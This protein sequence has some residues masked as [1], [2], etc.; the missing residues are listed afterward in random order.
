M[1]YDSSTIYWV[2]IHVTVLALQVKQQSSI[3]MLLSNTAGILLSASI[4]QPCM[5]SVRFFLFGIVFPNFSLRTEGMS[6]SA[7]QTL[8]S[9]SGGKS[10]WA[11]KSRCR[12]H[13]PEDSELVILNLGRCMHKLS[14][15]LV[16]RNLGVRHQWATVLHRIFGYQ[17]E[18]SRS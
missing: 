9:M 8:S 14:H 13:N 7:N 1:K 3:K 2:S 18:R 11:I 15:E 5:V 10:P 12:L 16:S 4:V 6:S 17:N